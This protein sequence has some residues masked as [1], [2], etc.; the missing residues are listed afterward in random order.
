MVICPEIDIK[1]VAPQVAWDAFRNSGQACVAAK[2][3]Y[4]YQDIYDEFVAVMVQTTANL[5]V[6][7]LQNKMQ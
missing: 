6:G 2:R 1:A 4:V 7:P 5:K 3:I